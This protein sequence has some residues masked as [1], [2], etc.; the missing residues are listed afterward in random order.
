MKI[1]YELTETV[2]KRKWLSVYSKRN[3]LLRDSDWT[4]LL[5]SNLTIDCIIKW[6]NWRKLVKNVSETTYLEYFN[7]LDTLNSLEQ[8]MPI[9]SL[10]NNQDLISNIIEQK[11]SEK[12]L[13]IGSIIKLIKEEI[14]EEFIKNNVE[15]LEILDEKV[16]STVIKLLINKE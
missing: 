5:D 15:L 7:A 13:D 3:Q 6:A 4:Q 12:L 10:N 11:I 2:K 1:K 9:I 8:Q 14:K 16:N